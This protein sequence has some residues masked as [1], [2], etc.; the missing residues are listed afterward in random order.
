[1]PKKWKTRLI[2]GVLSHIG[3]QLA[4]GVLIHQKPRVSVLVPAVFDSAAEEHPLYRS[5]YGVP[6]VVRT[7]LALNEIPVVREIILVVSEADI[8][9]MAE[10]C[11]DFS[12]DRVR[13]ILRAKAAGVS[14]L[15]IGTYECDPA[16]DYIAICDPLCPFVSAALLE[17]S[18]SAAIQ[19]GAAAP[20]VAV[21][22]TIKIVADGAVSETPD[23]TAL[24]ELQS[25]IAVE[26]SLLKAALMTAGQADMQTAHVMEILESFQVT[27][28]LTK[29]S[30][31]N[32]RV[33]GPADIPAA[34]AIL[35]WR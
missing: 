10:I 9:R 33:F 25:P 16:A 5:L 24:R 18:L 7:L 14:A 12:L 13:K 28:R 6:V 4:E 34:E 32:I 30:E 3:P 17:Q 26:S 29:G 19:H 20:A 15:T 27:L 35:Q 31:E 23:R 22:D 11:E 8:P 21:K 2:R 1:M